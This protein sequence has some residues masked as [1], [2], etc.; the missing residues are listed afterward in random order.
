[1]T[2]KLFIRLSLMLGMIGALGLPAQA[3]TAITT[4][5]LT[6]AITTRATR[7]DIV[8][9]SNTGMAVGS[10]ALLI[11]GSVYQINAIS[12]TTITVTNTAYP[13]SHL[14]S[15]TVYVVPLG[16]Q[17]GRNPVGSCIR[18]TAGVVPLYSPYTIMFNLAT[19]DMA[20]CRGNV[21][22]RS[23]V[24]SNQYGYAASANP[25]ITP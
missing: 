23:W 10:T 11:D 8:V 21:G 6:N 1:M 13:A 7:Q 24:I 25:P 20:V 17:I 19:G 5:T 22:S 16:A 2:M 9:G 14:A 4:T 12:G 3:Q 18:G 15:V